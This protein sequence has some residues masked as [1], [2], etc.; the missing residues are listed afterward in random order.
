MVD[1]KA[2][3]RKY[4]K[5]E[6]VRLG[7]RLRNY[8][9]QNE[10][11]LEDLEILQTLRTSYKTPLSQ[12]FEILQKSIIK[13]NKTAIITYRVKRI[14]SII[15]KL[16][17]LESSQLPRIEDIAGCRCILRNNDEVYRLKKILEGSLFVKSD[18]N[19]YI[20]KP[21][22][23]GYKSLHLIVQTKDRS[24]E[25][26][27]VQI[28]CE[29]DHNWAT[30]VEITDLIYG[31]RIKELGND[32][33]LGRMLYLL[34]I[35][36]NKL[37]KIELRELIE[38]IIRKDYVKKVNSVFVNNSI[39]VRQQWSEIER[40]PDRNFYLIEVD[41]ENNSNIKSFRTFNEAERFYFERFKVNP[42]HNI[43]L[44]HISKATFEQISKAYSNYTLTYHAFMQDFLN[45][46]QELVRL[47]ISQNNLKNFSKYFSV[48]VETYFEVAKLQFNEMVR[49]QKTKCKGQKKYEWK[50]DINTTLKKIV[51]KREDLF[52][53]IKMNKLNFLHLVIKIKMTRVWKKHSKDFQSSIKQLI[54]DS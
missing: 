27:E 14:N 38:L 47:S 43:V 33:D 36:F 28:R 42:D 50:K 3:L 6:Y 13:V 39:K 11:P 9:S 30:L 8:S 54:S 34:S 35:G 15:S 23:D 25:P 26:I 4:T 21:K 20:A 2:I 49:M 19:D 44:T 45:K 31:T 37:E 52:Q 10:I 17:R 48:F 53:N 46:T 24:T 1:G 7:E 40:K 29:K 18:R 41:K 51:G 12:V 16:K 22:P 5:G 32:T